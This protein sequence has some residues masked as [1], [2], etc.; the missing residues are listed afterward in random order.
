MA[1]EQ[2]IDAELFALFLSSGAYLH[3]ARQYL[4]PQQIDQVDIDGCLAQL[5]GC[6]A[7]EQS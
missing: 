4:Q 3:Y 2:H 6:E 7:V 1:R 5:R